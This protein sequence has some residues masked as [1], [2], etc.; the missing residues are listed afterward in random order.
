MRAASAAL[1]L[2]ANLG[3]A[4]DCGRDRRAVQLNAAVMQKARVLFPNK[5]AMHLVDI[6]GYSERA[7]EYW[8]SGN[9]KIPADALAMILRSEWGLEFLEVL[10]D[11]SPAPW[12]RKLAAY[13]ATITAISLQKAAR[14]KM[15]EAFDA[16]A[17]LDALLI[18]DE[19]FYRPHVDAVRNVARPQGRPVARGRR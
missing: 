17:E 8:L 16:D 14:R 4:K 5:T 10:M 6:T 3:T 12:W 13:F 18:Q 11:G 2:K 9:A 19:A 1:A 15:Q 7:C